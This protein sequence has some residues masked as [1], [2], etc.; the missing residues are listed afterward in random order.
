MGQGRTI[1]LPRVNQDVKEKYLGNVREK[2]DSHQE[3]NQGKSMAYIPLSTICS[4]TK[5]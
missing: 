3:P 5:G 2:V 1:S 4:C